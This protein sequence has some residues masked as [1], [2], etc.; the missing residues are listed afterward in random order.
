MT[1]FHYVYTVRTDAA[2]Q[3]I[4]DYYSLK[5]VFLYFLV[6]RLMSRLCNLEEFCYQTR[7]AQRLLR[8][9][10]QKLAVNQRPSGQY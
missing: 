9:C 2:S 10:K 5:D 7:M 3:R 1:L 6:I 4:P 8:A